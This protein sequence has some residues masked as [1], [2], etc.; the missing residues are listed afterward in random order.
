MSSKQF[1]QPTKKTWISLGMLTAFLTVLYLIALYWLL[2]NGYWSTTASD[3]WSQTLGLINSVGEFFLPSLEFIYPP[4]PI[5][6]LIPFGMLPRSVPGTEPHLAGIFFVVL[7]LG[8]FFYQLRSRRYPLPA[9]LFVT[10]MLAVHPSV[11]WTATNGGVQYAL[12]FVLFYLLGLATVQYVE[13]PGSRSAINLGIVLILYFFTEPSSL[14]FMV[15]FSL[16]L[17]VILIGIIPLAYLPIYV[18]TTLIPLLFGLLSWGYLSWLYTGDFWHFWTVSESIFVGGWTAA[19]EYP[20]LQDWGGSFFIPLGIAILF[21][22]LSIPAI[23]Y[24]FVQAWTKKRN[25]VLTL[26]IVC[27]PALILASSTWIYFPRYPSSILFVLP[28]TLMVLL[29][30]LP[31]PDNW[32]RHVGLIVLVLVGPIGGYYSQFSYPAGELQTW[33]QAALAELKE[34]PVDHS[35]LQLSEWLMK[36]GPVP[37]TMI[38][39]ELASVVISKQKHPGNFLFPAEEQFA[40]SL[41]YPEA[42]P[43]Q[44]V[45]PDPDRLGGMEDPINTWYPNLYEDGRAGYDLVYDAGGWRVWKK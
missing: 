43:E 23:L 27:F 1:W 31:P 24:C 10:L 28:A 4:V 40:L 33:K 2:S 12:S 15:V 45:V 7:V 35:E 34:S 29:I 19:V 37:K 30:Y 26:A 18:F 13:R 6:A 42:L 11:V 41:R 44:I 22:F 20:W 14:V 3:Y 36:Q 25:I 8:L 21:T 9:A 17:M 39:H 32:L 38:S 5:Y 16:V